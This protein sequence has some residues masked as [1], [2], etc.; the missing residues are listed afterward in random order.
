MIFRS[1]PLCI[2]YQSIDTVAQRYE[3]KLWIQLKWLT[4]RRLDAEVADRIASGEE[5]VPK[6]EFQ[7]GSNLEVSHSNRHPR[8]MG[9]SIYEKHYLIQ[10][11]SS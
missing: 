10:Y 5:W 6:L 3:A 9:S 8:T 11:L 2:Y 4:R 7:D 1:A